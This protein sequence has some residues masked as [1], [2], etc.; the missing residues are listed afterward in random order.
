[1]HI[2]IGCEQDYLTLAD[3]SS[4]LLDASLALVEHHPNTLGT[5]RTLIEHSS[6]YSTLFYHCSNTIR[7]QPIL[8]DTTILKSNIPQHCST[9]SN[10][11]RTCFSNTIDNILECYS[12]AL[13]SLIGTFFQTQHHSSSTQCHQFIS[14]QPSLTGCQSFVC[15]LVFFS[16]RTKYGA[17]HG[18]NHCCIR[19]WSPL[20]QL[21]KPGAIALHSFHK[22]MQLVEHLCRVW[23]LLQPCKPGVEALHSWH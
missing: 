15:L 19:H 4:T 12:W 3:H 8:I 5:S 7:T 21:C 18:I 13:L 2:A 17:R 10:T 22:D 16:A 20:L 6:Y 1:M 11:T 14:C 9:L 23:S